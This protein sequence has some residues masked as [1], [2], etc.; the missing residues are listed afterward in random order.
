LPHLHRRL[1]FRKIQFRA[2]LLNKAVAKE[3]PFDLQNR[4]LLRH[5][6]QFQLQP[7]L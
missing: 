7:N 4:F 5:R 1:W 2:L 6:G 3:Y